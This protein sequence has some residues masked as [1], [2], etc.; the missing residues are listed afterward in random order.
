MNLSAAQVQRY[1]LLGM[2]WYREEELFS[3]QYATLNDY[4]QVIAAH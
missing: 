1:G 2:A 4:S 3:G